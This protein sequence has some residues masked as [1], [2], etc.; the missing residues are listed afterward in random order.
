MFKHGQV[1]FDTSSRET[2]IHEFLMRVTPLQDG[3]GALVSD[4]T[5]KQSE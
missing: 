2:C 1:M 5:P 3:I 4:M